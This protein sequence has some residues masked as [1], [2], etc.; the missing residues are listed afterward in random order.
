MNTKYPP[1]S[2]PRP[3]HRHPCLHSPAAAAWEGRSHSGA[4][5]HPH[6]GVAGG[7]SEDGGGLARVT[8]DAAMRRERGSSRV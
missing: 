1:G 2:S 4:P 7:G 8:C 3:V 5:L 6:Q